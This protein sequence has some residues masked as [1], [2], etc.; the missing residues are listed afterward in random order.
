[1]RRGRGYFPGL[2]APRRLRFGL[3]LWD[4]FVRFVASWGKMVFDD[5]QG[6]AEPEFSGFFGLLISERFAG[7]NGF[8]V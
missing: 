3:V 7:L 5:G 1:M 2:W 6:R 4:V 8:G